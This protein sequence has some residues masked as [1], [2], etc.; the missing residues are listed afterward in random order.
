MGRVVVRGVVERR[1][2]DGRDWGGVGEGVAWGRGA[3]GL[4]GCIAC[5][6]GRGC[7]SGG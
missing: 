6:V 1:S 3:V 4:A 7:G 5:S 2:F